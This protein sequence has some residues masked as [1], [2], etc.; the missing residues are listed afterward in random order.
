M[1]ARKARNIRETTF[2]EEKKQSSKE[3]QDPK[4]VWMLIIWLAIILGFTLL[5]WFIR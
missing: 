3:K 4:V 5:Q 1:P 2:S